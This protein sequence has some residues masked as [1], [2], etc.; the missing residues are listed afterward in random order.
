MRGQR[1]TARVHGT[2][3]VRVDSTLS[4]LADAVKRSATKGARIIISVTLFLYSW[5]DKEMPTRG[6]KRSTNRSQGCD[7]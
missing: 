7:I 2:L 3:S 5:V 1:A 6:A 4:A